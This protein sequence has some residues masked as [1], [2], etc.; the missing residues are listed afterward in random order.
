MSVYLAYQGSRSN[1]PAGTGC[2]GPDANDSI[3]DQRVTIGLRAWLNRDNL[4]NNDITGAPLDFVN[5]F[6]FL[7]LGGQQMGSLQ[8]QA[9]DVRLKRDIILVGRRDDGLG[10]YR[11]RY[12][13]SD[14]VYVGVMAQEVA[15]IHPDAVVRDAL[16]DYLRVDYGRLGLKLM[17][18][19]EWDARS[20]SERL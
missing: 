7:G 10:L 16:D 3:T 6:S 19:P 18:L 12:L 20:K 5:P 8:A 14:T 4:R 13:W 11:Y 9:S 2:C 15:L 17:T 1:F